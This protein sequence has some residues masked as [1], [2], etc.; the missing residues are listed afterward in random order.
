MHQQGFVAPPQSTRGRYSSS[1]PMSWCYLWPHY[2]PTWFD[3]SS[4]VGSMQP[5][6]MKR[7]VF[8]LDTHSRRAMSE[9]PCWKHNAID[10]RV[11]WSYSGTSLSDHRSKALWDN[12]SKGTS[13]KNSHQDSST[14]LHARVDDLL[15]WVVLIVQLSFQSLARALSVIRTS[16]QV[17]PEVSSWVVVIWRHA[18]QGLNH[19]RIHLPVF[20]VDWSG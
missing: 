8:P 15:F 5:S 20:L 9:D 2:G 14:P 7:C 1:V 11:P 16:W 6:A 18:K 12:L 10:H 4:V 13:Q 17:D 19:G 3:P